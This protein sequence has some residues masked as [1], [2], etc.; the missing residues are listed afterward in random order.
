M[1]PQRLKGKRTAGRQGTPLAKMFAA[2][3]SQGNEG[4][5]SYVKHDMQQLLLQ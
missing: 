1:I 4:K 2:K 5:M 3:H